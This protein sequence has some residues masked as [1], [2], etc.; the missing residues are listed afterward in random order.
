[1]I[2]LID[3]TTP[4][5]FRRDDKQRIKEDAQLY[6]SRL[7]TEMPTFP[8]ERAVLRKL[9]FAVIGQFRQLANERGFRMT[10]KLSS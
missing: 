9:T 8:V 10:S 1:M 2:E 7:W 3:Y 4:E 6:A 5:N